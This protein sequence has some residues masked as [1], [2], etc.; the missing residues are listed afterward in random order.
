MSNVEP[1]KS[2]IRAP[3]APRREPVQPGPKLNTNTT[4]K[5]GSASSRVMLVDFRSGEPVQRHPEIVPL[6]V[7]G[8]MIKSAVPRLVEN[9][10]LKLLVVLKRSAAAL[11]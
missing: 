5:I 2:P 3:R 6:L 8:W 10:G 9:Q 1:T 4:L 7:D 11:S